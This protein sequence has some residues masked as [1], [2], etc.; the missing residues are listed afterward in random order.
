MLDVTSHLLFI[1]VDFSGDLGG[2]L[3]GDHGGD[4]SGNLG[5]DLLGDHG[6]HL[7]GDLGGDLCDG[8]L[9]DHG[10]DLNGDLYKPPLLSFHSGDHPGVPCPQ[11]IRSCT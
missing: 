10:G 3:L 2:D 8:L 9:G 1:L 5:G 11:L 4:L 7:S 6:G